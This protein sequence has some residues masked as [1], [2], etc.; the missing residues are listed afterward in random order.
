MAERGVKTRKTLQK[1]EF[2]RVNAILT[3]DLCS[4][5]VTVE[6]ANSRIAELTEVY[7][8]YVEAAGTYEDHLKYWN[9]VDKTAAHIKE[10]DYMDGVF[11]D[12]LDCVQDYNM[13]QRSSFLQVPVE[14]STRQVE[15]VVDDDR[16]GDSSYPRKENTSVKE[17]MDQLEKSHMET[18]N[19]LRELE[20]AERQ[21]QVSMRGGLDPRFLEASPPAGGTPAQDTTQRG[22]TST[23]LD[24]FQ[25]GTQD[26]NGGFR[27]H[28][29]STPHVSGESRPARLDM[30]QLPEPP[31]TPVE[32][33]LSHP[34]D[35]SRRR[36]TPP[37]Q[38]EGEGGPVCQR[39]NLARLE[40]PKFTGQMRDFQMWWT[41]FVETVDSEPLIKASEKMLRLR[42]CLSGEAL[43]L[44]YGLGPSKG[45]YAVAKDRLERKYGGAEKE[46]TYNMEDLSKFRA[47][48][49]NNTQDLEKFLALLDTV[50][51][52]L[53]DDGQEGELGKGT[54][55]YL[56]R[57]KLN[58][59]LLTAYHWWLHQTGTKESVEALRDY[60]VYAAD[61][62][63]RASLSGAPVDSGARRGQ[64]RA[65]TTRDED[66]AASGTGRGE[67]GGAR[68]NAGGS[69]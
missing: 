18:M 38:R 3:A 22:L 2:V 61:F 39:H 42:G 27:P 23:V 29:V 7:E 33:Y 16:V 13:A 12:T 20:A 59:T 53:L 40:V 28:Q 63:A 47:V 56:L 65:L 52:G 50:I 32:R 24:K 41:A 6:S 34:S 25:L 5:H 46:M 69:A 17:L 10:M 54:L 51:V 8:N 14:R 11:S 36:P 1:A 67:T 9:C 66:T 37:E 48:R 31:Q 49:E 4:K 64:G 45:S 58:V 21:F 44:I 60:T 68:A 26:G 15:T 57:Q 30:F 62:A 43:K 19:T 35:G 55:Y